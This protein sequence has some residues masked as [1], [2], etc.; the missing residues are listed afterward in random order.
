MRMFGLDCGWN[1]YV[2]AASHVFG[3]GE[4]GRNE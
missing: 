3:A 2:A 4:T 1:M